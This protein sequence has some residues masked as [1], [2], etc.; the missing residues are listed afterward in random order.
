L[1]IKIN[2]KRRAKAIERQADLNYK[3]AVQNATLR[4]KREVNVKKRR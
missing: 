2:E 1:I 3:E 4:Y